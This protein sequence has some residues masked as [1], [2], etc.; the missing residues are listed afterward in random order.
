M[1]RKS[2]LLFLALV[3]TPCISSAEIKTYTHTVKQSFG[4]S[5]S[6]DDARVAAVHKAKREALEKAG[7]YLESLTIVKNNMVEKDEI[8]ALAAGV[9]KAEIVSQENFHTKDAF[10]IIIVAKVD[11]DTSI[12]EKRIKKLLQD[13][14]LLKKYQEIKKRE[15]EL[16]VKIGKLEE[17]NRKLSTSPASADTQKKE[18]LKK[19]FRET[20][21]GLT[22]VEWINKALALFE[23][24]KHD[25][26]K[27]L[28]YFTR[29]IRLDSNY[30]AAYMGRGFVYHG[31]GQYQRAVE[32]YDQAI[33]L[34]PKVAWTYYWRGLSYVGLGQYQRAIEDYDQAIR[35]DPE[36]AT[37]YND[38]GVAY[39]SLDQY[40]RA[41][42]D[43]NHAI[44]LNP[45]D[46]KAYYNRG[47]V[48]Q[49]LGQYQ[50]AIE[51]YDQAIRLNPKDAGAYNNRGLAY[52]DLGKKNSACY[53][54]RKACELGICAGLNW[55]KENGYCR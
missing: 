2:C 31:L 24:G 28:D 51:D 38:R 4:G 10:G 19:L 11:V 46:A 3:L 1:L 32:D 23:D 21:Q 18:E 12:L 20:S 36:N 49:D 15:K 47:L 30:A 48:Y 17:E 35:L 44:R 50:R 40:Y 7:T 29:A 33:R 45:K 54:W 39:G 41:I 8:L 25:T 14:E 9:L 22:A 43:F 42:E 27:E 34:N 16:L 13:R 26:D 52:Q 53:D 55:A 6:P 37:H 5:Q